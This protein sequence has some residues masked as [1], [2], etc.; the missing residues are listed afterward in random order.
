MESHICPF[1]LTEPKQLDCTFFTFG[2]NFKGNTSD[3]IERHSSENI[4]QH[5]VVGI[6][7]YFY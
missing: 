6:I 3:E 1:D 4:Q 7:D 5:L 2:C